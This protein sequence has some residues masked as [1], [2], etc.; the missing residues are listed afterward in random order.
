MKSKFLD[1]N[2]IVPEDLTKDL[3][4]KWKGKYLTGRY[5]SGAYGL[6]IEFY[7]VFE[8]TFV[9]FITIA[10]DKIYWRFIEDK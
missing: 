3:L 6:D 8:S 1:S 10:Q 7:G 5:L 2:I 4:F 9:S